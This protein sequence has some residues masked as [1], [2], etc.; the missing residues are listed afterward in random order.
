MTDTEAARQAARTLADT[1]K[2]LREIAPVPDPS[3]A[4]PGAV[5]GR[6]LTVTGLRRAGLARD[7][8][9]D[10]EAARHGLGISSKLLS[11]AVSVKPRS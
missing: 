9:D 8:Y 10:A 5:L 7:S 2:R 4:D 1:R 6:Y 3:A 11:L